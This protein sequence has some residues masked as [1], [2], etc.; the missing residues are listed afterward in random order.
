MP[1]GGP[2]RQAPP[3]KGLHG[4]ALLHG[5]AP[6]ET[7]KPIFFG[8][9]IGDTFIECPKTEHEWLYP[10]GFEGKS[11]LWYMIHHIHLEDFL[12][13]KLVNQF[14]CR[15]R[16]WLDLRDQ[17]TTLKGHYKLTLLDNCRDYYTIED[18]QQMLT[19]LVM[20]TYNKVGAYNIFVKWTKDDELRKLRH[21]IW[22]LLK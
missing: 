11:I 1:P 21:T 19:E 10:C 13:P 3:W 5:R 9:T 14:F 2:W 18:H 7:H 15:G 6:M 8:T 22:S 20:K 4:W 16:N 17:M 12:D